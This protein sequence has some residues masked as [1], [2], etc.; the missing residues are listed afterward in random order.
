MEPNSKLVNAE[1]GRQA[2]PVAVSPAR[3]LETSH[4]AYP[5]PVPSLSDFFDHSRDVA[6]IHCGHT[7]RALVVS[8]VEL[9]P[10]SRRATGLWGVGAPGDRPWTPD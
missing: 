7:F 4:H 8:A 2:G 6:A 1:H 3:R 10:R 5:C 9:G